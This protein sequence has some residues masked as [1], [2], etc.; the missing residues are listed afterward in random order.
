MNKDDKVVIIIYTVSQAIKIEKILRKIG[1]TCKLIPVP[2]F[3]SSDCGVCVSIRKSDEGKV[4]Q[5]LQDS[6]I[7]IQGL[8][9][10]E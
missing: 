10:I 2:R 4:R 1:I 6:N 9:S 7:D 5:I 8:Y 3:L